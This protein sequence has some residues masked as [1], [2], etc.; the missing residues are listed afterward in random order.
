VADAFP[1]SNINLQTEHWKMTRTIFH[2]AKRTK[3]S[4]LS[5]DRERWLIDGALCVTVLEV[6]THEKKVKK[7]PRDAA[8]KFG[9]G[10]GAN[11]IGDR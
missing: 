10:N 11:G 5:F 8:K 9:Q 3:R 4:T 2:K 1:Q 6:R 7:A